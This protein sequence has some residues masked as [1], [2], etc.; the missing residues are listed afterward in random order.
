MNARPSLL[1]RLDRVPMHA[2]VTLSLLLITLAA[3]VLS[4]TGTLAYDGAG[5]LIGAAV[6]V[7]ASVVFS[8][9]AGRLTRR[10]AHLPSSVITGLLIVLIAAPLRAPTDDLGAFLRDP[11]DLITLV[12]AAALAALIKTLLLWRGRPV[13]NPAAFALVLTGPLLVAL[14]RT[15]A[16][17]LW[18]VAAEPLAPFIVVT[19]ALVLIRT[20]L[21]APAL[22]LVLVATVLLTV[23]LQSFGGSWADALQTAVWQYP[24]LFLAAFMFSEPVTLPPLRWQRIAVGGLVGALLA[25]PML[26]SM[27]EVH[28]GLGPILLQPALALVIGN[29]LAFALGARRGCRLT[30]VRSERSREGTFVDLFFTA[31]PPLRHRA[32]QWVE[33]SLPHRADLRGQRR[34]FSIAS[35][36]GASEVRIGIRAL[37]PLSSFKQQLLSLRPGQQ[38]AITRQGGDFTPAPDK[39]RLML[40]SGIGVTPFASHLQAGRSDNGGGTTDDVLVLALRPG[41]P[42][43]LQD[44]LAGSGARVVLMAPERPADAPESFEH[45]TGPLQADRLRALVPDIAQRQV[46]TSGSPDQVR[47]LTKLAKEA[48]SGRVMVDAFS[49]Y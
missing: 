41:D 31:D 43:P 46:L 23:A 2:V 14:G 19:G 4:F 27:A 40:A 3:A 22:A 29:V 37:E 33:L 34:V 28:L 18:W 42:V 16:P 35:A 44:V 25:A 21:V 6:A 45:E 32:G 38:V 30:L 24:T 11:D 26:A 1:S 15:S 5:I 8:A 10:P 9:L 48:G 49:G 47:A 13:V 17:E 36:P 7:A 12:L 39:P 20:R